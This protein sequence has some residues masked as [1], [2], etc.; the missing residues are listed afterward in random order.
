[1][2]RLRATLLTFAPL[3]GVGACVAVMAFG[4]WRG[5]DATIVWGFLATV[6][7]FV[8]W[9]ILL[10]VWLTSAGRALDAATD[11]WFEEKPA[12]EEAATRASR[13]VLG[14]VFRADHRARALGLLGL[15]AEARCD[16]ATAAA[17]FEEAE[18]ALPWLAPSAATRRARV[19]FLSHAALALVA[20]GRLDDAREKLER[21]ERELERPDRAQRFEW[22]YDDRRLFGGA[23]SMR[24]AL[25]HIERDRDAPGL[26]W[27]ARVFLAVAE[28]A[29]GKAQDWLA[30]ERGVIQLDLTERERGLARA[31]EQRS[32]LLLGGGPQRGPLAVEADGWAAACLEHA[33]LR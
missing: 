15:V 10:I 27:L 12:W 8:A 32:A 25:E 26:V 16:F 23:L 17:R 28:G 6:P 20:L 30:R 7:C 1:M 22:L 19:L 21:A 31:L 11:A 24:L 3:G 14:R 33:L 9:P 29:P 5:S 18:A 2:S 13:R 4:A